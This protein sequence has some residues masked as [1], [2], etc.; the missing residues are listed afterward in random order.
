MSAG[1]F[2]CS[3]TTCLY[4]VSASRRDLFEK[5]LFHS[6]MWVAI[7]YAKKNKYQYFDVGEQLY[8]NHPQSI[9]PTRKELGISEFKAGFGGETKM[10]LD[11][12]LVDPVCK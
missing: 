9:R 5:P 6:L 2:V 10:S 11:I 12:L 8:P 1:L 3:E 7:L 4:G